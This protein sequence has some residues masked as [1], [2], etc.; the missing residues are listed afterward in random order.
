MTIH[1]IQMAIQRIGAGWAIAV[2]NLRVASELIRRWPNDLTSCSAHIA[3]ASGCIDN[4]R[5]TLLSLI[6][7]TDPA[8][9]DVTD[10]HLLADDVDRVIAEANNQSVYALQ[11][12]DGV[13]PRRDPGS[14]IEISR[15][16]NSVQALY[17][18]AAAV[19]QRAADFKWRN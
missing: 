11:I 1:E 19:Q 9:I 16:A 4:D 14:P 8:A 13:A 18:R 6:N 7:Q 5:P 12:R 17:K 10:L 2:E 15:L 3:V